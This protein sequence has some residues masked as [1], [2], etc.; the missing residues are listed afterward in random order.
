MACGLVGYRTRI[1]MH[2]ASD[3]GNVQN[4]PA[5]ALA[6]HTWLDV[7]R[8][9]GTCPRINECAQYA[10]PVEFI[11]VE[12]LISS[13]FS[14]TQTPAYKQHKDRIPQL[15]WSK[16]VNVTLNYALLNTGVCGYMFCA[17]SCTKH[18]ANIL[19]VKASG[20]RTFKHHELQHCASNSL[21]ITT[22]S[23]S[24]H[25]ATA[26]YPVVSSD[27]EEWSPLNP[28]L[29]ENFDACSAF[30]DANELAFSA[31]Q[32]YSTDVCDGMKSDPGSCAA[33]TSSIRHGGNSFPTPT[34][35]SG[36]A[37]SGSS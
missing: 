12:F 29:G 28:P 19:D 37:S 32:N 18:V 25:F 34:V 5:V 30:L 4:W 27:E 7:F 22:S 16:L 3:Q 10:R 33:N 14:V 35:V 13:P 24:H 20:P 17:F 6:N 8:H 23:W 9:D 11:K 21:T 26:A 36:R 1:G 31:A 15:Q 2:C